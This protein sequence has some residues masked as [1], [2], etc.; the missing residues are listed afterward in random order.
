MT[1]LK[2]YRVYRIVQAK[3][4]EEAWN[5]FLN[6]SDLLNELEESFNIEEISE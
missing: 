1:K 6:E 3:N 4:Q 5:D 2:T